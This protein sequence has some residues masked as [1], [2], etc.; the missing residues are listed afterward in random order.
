M[1]DYAQSVPSEAADSYCGAINGGSMSAATIIKVVAAACTMN[2]QAM[3]VLLQ[4]ENCLVTDPAP[5]GGSYQTA[6]GFGCPDTSGCDANYFGFFN[7]VYH[8]ARQFQVYQKNPDVFNFAV[9]RTSNVQ[10]SPDSNCGSSPVT[11]QTA[12]TAGLYNYT[13]YQP[14]QAALNAGYGTGDSC[15]AYGNRNFWLFFSDWFGSPIGSEYAWLIQSLTYANGDNILTKGYDE[16]ITLKALNVSRHPWYNHGDY[17]VRLGTWNPANRSSA[18]MPTRVDMQESEVDINQV[19][20]FQFHVDPQ[21]E[22][23]FVEA[24][25]LVVEGYTWMP[26]PGFSPT[27]VVTSNPY[28]WQVN[29]VSY[30]SGTGQMSPGGTQSMVV[31][32]TNT[33]NATWDKTTPP[34][35]LATWPPDRP[36][37]VATASSGKW[38]SPTRI[39]QFNESTVPPGGQASFQFD[40]RVPFSGTFYEQLNMVAGVDLR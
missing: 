18:I 13:P 6:T 24:M 36:S 4:K 5:C 22:G 34:I 29:S 10:Y 11:M 26:W 37:A 40:V 1:R 35:W 27:V 28:Q 7:Q 2:P 17:P 9:G 23:T 16:V 25:N 19:G 15:S 32:V 39:T 8:A 14:N 20:T 31:R 38:P 21:V 30:S 33:G 3:L 12:A